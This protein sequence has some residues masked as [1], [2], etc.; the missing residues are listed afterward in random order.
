MHVLTRACVH[1]CS[2]TDTQTR[3]HACA[4]VHT[5]TYVPTQP[6]SHV[7]T[8]GH[9]H[10]RARAAELHTQLRTLAHTHTPCTQLHTHACSQAWDI[11][12]ARCG[13]TD[14]NFASEANVRVSACASL[15]SCMQAYL[16]VSAGLEEVKILFMQYCHSLLLF[17]FDSKQ[18]GGSGE[19]WGGEGWGGVGRNAC[20]QGVTVWTSEPITARRRKVVGKIQQAAPI[21]ARRREVVGRSRQ[22]EPIMAR[23]RFVNLAR[24]QARWHVVDIV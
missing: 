10:A 17:S 15:C 20:E 11:R 23:R 9:M 1:V 19:G 14:L 16:T 8:H 6:A 24:V 21:T 2:H 22:R 13:R 7:R 18:E 5:H 4:H 3:T 12:A